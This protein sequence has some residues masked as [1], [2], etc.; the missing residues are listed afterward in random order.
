M[1]NAHTHSDSHDEAQLMTVAQAA[2]LMQVSERTV[3]RMVARREL[4][5]VK[6]MGRLIRIRRKEVVRFIDA[7]TIPVLTT[8]R[9][10]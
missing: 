8:G 1:S 5:H 7:H 4:A 3:R 9:V 2:E 10:R 6:V